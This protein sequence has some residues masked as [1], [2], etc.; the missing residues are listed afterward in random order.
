MTLR[1]APRVAAL[2]LLTALLLTVMAVPAAAHGRG[3]E[4]TNFS[5]RI[6]QAPDLPGVTWE[7]FGGDQY[8]SVTNTTD[9]EVVVTGYEGEPYARIGPDGVFVNL[10]SEATYVN[11]DRYA[12][13]EGIPPDVGAEQEPRW[14]LVTGDTTYAWH[15]HRIHW[16]SPA[17]PPQVTDPTKRTVVNPEWEVP[18]IYGDR[19]E[20]VTGELTWVPPPS[21]V[22][23]IALAAL[24]TL[25]ALLGLRRSRDADGE[26][27]VRRMVTPAAIVLG[28]VAL[29]NVTH[30][31]DDLV[32]IPLP[33][34]TKLVSAIQTLLFVALGLFGAVV[35]QRG[36]DGAFTALGVGAGGIL[37]GQGLLY[38]DVLSYSQSASVFP[39]WSAMLIV[40]LSLVQALPVGAVAVMG[41]R[42]LAALDEPAEPAAEEIAAT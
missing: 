24:L 1:F 14:D 11:A 27:W 26:D 3:T 29:L 9:T 39:H 30:L 31:V 37:V 10:A 33:L 13:I 25:P 5:S 34:S 12:D 35:A 38:L 16:M 32:A 19:T 6:L 36:K 18:F 41:N 40:A 22:T 4:S 23:W 42:R 17:L 28:V 7:V 2:A 21:P 8:L 20:T 15:D